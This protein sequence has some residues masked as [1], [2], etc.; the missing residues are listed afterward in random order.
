MKRI[1]II[2]ALLLGVA[3]SAA[4]QNKPTGAGQADM[5]KF[6]PNP[7]SFFINFEFQR[8]Y[9][10]NYTLQIY[11]F[12]GRKVQ[13]IKNTP[14]RVNLRLDDFYRGIYIFQLRDKY[15]RILES[16]RFQVIK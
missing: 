3:F 2:S 5:L 13:E 7:A 11:N 9:D 6:Y 10:R 8:S 4:S 14:T 16:G 12:M 1:L 15:G